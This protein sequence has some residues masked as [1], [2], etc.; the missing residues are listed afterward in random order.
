MSNEKRFINGKL[1][2]MN[3]YKMIAALTCFCIVTYVADAAVSNL[4]TTYEKP[5]PGKLSSKIDQLVLVDLRKNG[6]QP[7][8]L[9]SEAV[10]MRRIYQDLAGAMPRWWDARNFIRSKD[11][12]KRAKL[13][14][15]LMTT[16]HFRE[17]WT[18]KWSDL[19]RVKSEFP[20]NLWPNATQAYNRWIYDA[21][22]NNMPYDQFAKKLLLSSGSNFRDPEVNLY[23]AVSEKTPEG[24][25]RAVMLTFMGT[26]YDKWPVGMQ[27]ELQ[28]FFSRIK[29]KSTD[30]WKEQIVY[31]DMTQG[32]K[33]SAKLPDGTRVTLDPGKDARQVFV[34]WLVS[35]NNPWFARCAV[36]RIWFWLMGRGIIHEADDIMFNSRASNPALLSYLEEEFIKS[37]FDL[38]HIIRLIVNSDTYQQSFIPRSDAPLAME[39]FAYYTTHRLDAEIIVDFIDS[40]GGRKEKY[41]SPIPEPFTFIPPEN[42]TISL[43]DGS[44]SSQFL[45]RFG[46]PAR[47]SGMLSERKNFSTS[48]QRL[49]MLNSNYIQQKLVNGGSMRYFLRNRKLKTDQAYSAIYLLILSRYP[50]AKEL[51]EIN[52]YAAKYRTGKTRA[53]RDLAWSLLNSK[54]FMYHH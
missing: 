11:P 3:R 40:L 21:V 23:R 22:K 24:L 34:D 14:D 6:I 41:V 26:R 16:E 9:A 35:P 13:I 10:F 49:F 8:P 19:L 15:R 33:V 25:T 47:D 18:L 42:R 50:S 2:N 27:K 44:I 51:R 31:V 28:K 37:K 52:Q 45:S 54:E 32:K 53:L 20:I 1:M 43:A 29:Y 36:N 4:N 48:S 5:R 7:A 30:E 12:R 38:Q 39:K 17:Y 46:R